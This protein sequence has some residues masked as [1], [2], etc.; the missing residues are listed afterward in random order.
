M[1]IRSLWLYR[2]ISNE[3]ADGIGE[4]GASDVTISLSDQMSTMSLPPVSGGREFRSVRR[5]EELC[6]VDGGIALPSLIVLS[7]SRI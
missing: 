1:Y 4:R 2:G 5:H 3:A 7:E 6:N